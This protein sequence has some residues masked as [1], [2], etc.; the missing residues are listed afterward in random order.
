MRNFGS[1]GVYKINNGF[2]EVAEVLGIST[3]AA[4]LRR[5]RLFRRIKQRLKGK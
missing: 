3:A 5:E 1:S 4:K 2:K